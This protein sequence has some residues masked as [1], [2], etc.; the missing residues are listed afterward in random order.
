MKTVV[1]PVD[2]EGRRD[3]VTVYFC[4]EQEYA[5]AHAKHGV[6]GWGGYNR[7]I[8]ARA[9]KLPGVSSIYVGPD[10]D[11][12]LVGHEVGHIFL[13][14]SVHPNG[15]ILGTLHAFRWGCPTMAFSK[16]FRWRDPEGLRPI[17]AAF[18][19]KAQS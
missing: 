19:A 13:G 14:D 12:A 3:N 5:A 2:Y 11:A 8:R 16:L 9:F 10:F 4:N 7:F 18:I 6:G 15:P 1:L 17:G